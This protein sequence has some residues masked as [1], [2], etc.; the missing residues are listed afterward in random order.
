MITMA[1][2]AM[3]TNPKSYLGPTKKPNVWLNIHTGTEHNI[4]H[5]KK[6]IEQGANKKTYTWNQD[7]YLLYVPTFPFALFF[8]F[9]N[10]LSK[11]IFF[12]TPSF[13]NVFSWLLP[14]TPLFEKLYLEM[15]PIPS[16]PA[17]PPSL[18][19]VQPKYHHQPTVSVII[20]C[21]LLRDVSISQPPPWQGGG[22]LGHAS[23]ACGSKG[24]RLPL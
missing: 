20:F 10:P 5:K 7:Q 6:S 13:L 19:P 11:P 15:P 17:I 14:H 12:A 3:L 18:L 23:H 22:V 1:D 16:S 24:N 2:K 4:L 21:S 9:S 8:L